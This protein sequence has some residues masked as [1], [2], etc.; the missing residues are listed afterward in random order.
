[1]KS[2][3]GLEFRRFA[4]NPRSAGS[5]SRLVPQRSN[6]SSNHPTVDYS[7]E[8]HKQLRTDIYKKLFHILN[9]SAITNNLTTTNVVTTTLV[10]NI[11]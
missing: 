2:G 9:R 11:Q 5:Q 3:A 8:K 7:T 10:F 4:G 1:M 6:G